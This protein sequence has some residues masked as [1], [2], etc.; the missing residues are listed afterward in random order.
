MKTYIL[1]IIPRIKKFSKKLDDLTSLADKHWVILDDDTNLKSVYIFRKN[2]VLLISLNGEIQK[3]KWEYLDQN[4]IMIDIKD[5]S[6][7]FRQGFFN[8]T[9]LALMLDG[10]NE[11]CLMIDEAK[12]VDGLNTLLSVEEFLQSEYLSPEFKDGVADDAN[13]I[14][15]NNNLNFDSQSEFSEEDTD[16]HNGGV[17]VFLFFALV[18]YLMIFWF[19][20]Y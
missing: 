11:F 5:K 15:I 3:G 9:V 2:G 16:D 4:S 1:D 6:Y 8:K 7:L 20:R 14:Y 17:L 13:P 12:Y 10:K 18:I 19:T